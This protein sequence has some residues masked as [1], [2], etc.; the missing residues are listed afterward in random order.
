MQAGVRQELHIARA[1]SRG[2]V[3]NIYVGSVARVLPGM[4]SAFIEIGLERAGFL[5]VGDI[6]EER[7]QANDARGKPIEKILSEG[8]SRLAQGIK[9]PIGTTG[10]RPATQSSN[11]GRLMS[12]LAQ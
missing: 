8:Q 1:A 6:W 12:Y 9:D 5:H 10:P 7:P 4:Q 3:G 2:L 11:P